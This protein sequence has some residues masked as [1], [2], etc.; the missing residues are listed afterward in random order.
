MYFSCVVFG[1]YFYIK[2][3]TFG[4]YLS[5]PGMVFAHASFSLKTMFLLAKEVHVFL[6]A[7]FCGPFEKSSASAPSGYLFDG[8]FLID[9]AS[10]K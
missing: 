7:S 1:Y 6:F 10:K 9:S 5:G 2:K 8:N 4:K 3:I